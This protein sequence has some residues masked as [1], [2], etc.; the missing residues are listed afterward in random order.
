MTDKEPVINFKTAE[1]EVE[2]M[3]DYYGIDIEMIRDKDSRSNIERAKMKLVKAVTQG[4]LEFVYENDEGGYMQL[5]C[6]QHLISRKDGHEQDFR[7]KEVD[8][9][10][11]IAMKHCGDDDT[12]GK[13]QAMMASLAG[14]TATS[15]QKVRGVDLGLME[16]LGM[17]FLSV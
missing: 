1:E 4:R 2:K 9:R 14:V 15:M 17:V 16:S 13:I 3:F 7:Y 5:T 8:G 6:V 12:M 11:K 10:S